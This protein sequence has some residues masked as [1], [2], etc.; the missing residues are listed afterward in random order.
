MGV[1]SRSEE[2]QKEVPMAQQLEKQ[3]TATTTKTKA[4]PT[5]GT[6]ARKNGDGLES[7]VQDFL[8]RF[9]RA[10]TAGDGK[11]I[12]T[13]WATPAY[14]MADEMS[15]AVGT[16]EEVEQ[17]FAGAKDQYNERGITDTRAEILHLEWLTRRIAVVDVRWPYLDEDGKELG[18]ETSTYTLW[19]DDDGEL[20]MRV[21]VMRGASAPQTAGGAQ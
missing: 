3:R 1:G 16:T 19:K 12:A 17:F 21:V 13:M 8:D 5:N 10:L 4:K 15:R 14:V 11:T 18:E 20:K 2:A 9:A 7:G 6:G